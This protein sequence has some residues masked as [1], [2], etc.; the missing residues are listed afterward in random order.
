MAGLAF[1]IFFLVAVSQTNSWEQR[2]CFASSSFWRWPCVQGENAL[3]LF[4]RSSKFLCSAMWWEAWAQISSQP[5]LLRSHLAC[6]RWKT[7][8][9]INS[10][11]QAEW[12]TNKQLIKVAFVCVCA[13]FPGHPPSYVY[14]LAR[15][16][17][18]LARWKMKLRTDNERQCS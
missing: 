15:H 13:Y 16:V 8:I 17:Q 12:T 18:C 7:K 4:N 5:V 6:D 11:A 10:K 14:S 9:K 2:D 1:C 3:N